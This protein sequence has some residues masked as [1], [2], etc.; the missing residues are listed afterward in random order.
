MEGN[1]AY[2][3][4][5]HALLAFSDTLRQEMKKWGV[6]VSIIE[7]TGFCTG[8][9]SFQCFHGDQEVIKT[10]S[11][12]YHLFSACN[13]DFDWLRRKGKYVVSNAISNVNVK[14]SFGHL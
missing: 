7:P 13:R 11:S 2:G 8:M 14:M 6:K 3:I 4:S 10:R 1:G 5:K 12:I 9:V